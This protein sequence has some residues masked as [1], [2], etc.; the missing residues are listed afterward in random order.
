MSG[1]TIL[2]ILQERSRPVLPIKEDAILESINGPEYSIM[3]SYLTKYDAFVEDKTFQKTLCNNI[4]EYVLDLS[5][6]LEPSQSYNPKNI[7]DYKIIDINLPH[8]ATLKIHVLEAIECFKFAIARGYPYHYDK[9]G[10]KNDKR[11]INLESITRLFYLDSREISNFIK[12]YFSL[13]PDISYDIEALKYMIKLTISRCIRVYEIDLI[14]LKHV[15]DIFKSL[16]ISLDYVY[17]DAAIDTILMDYDY[18]DMYDD[19]FDL[20]QYGIDYGIK[21]NDDNITRITKLNFSKE[22]GIDKIVSK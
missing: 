10:Y 4:M 17:Y 7:D 15:L 20:L 8:Y 11:Y 21:V 19:L 12:Y 9:P 18:D 1:L 16:N 14:T 3:L 2:S 6:I 22:I 13:F 5:D